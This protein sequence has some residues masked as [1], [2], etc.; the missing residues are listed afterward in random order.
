VAIDRRRLYEGLLNRDERAWRAFLDEFGGLIYSIAIKLRLQES[1]REDFF[2]DVCLLVYDSIGSLR[3][4]D[5]LASWLY[6]I[7]RRRGIESLRRKRSEVPLEDTAAFSREAV[8]C[9]T[10]E[11]DVLDRLARTEAVARLIDALALMQDR[12]R[13][14][15]TALYLDDPRPSYKEIASR[16]R[17]PVGSI[18]PTL[19][20]CMEKAQ[21]IME[22][23]SNKP[24]DPSA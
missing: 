18:G 2:Q 23:L 6:T 13:R 14:L 20:R 9:D 21:K 3:D 7:A 8:D 17:M 19:S 5:H 11:P 12:C 22:E 10:G 4:P 16:E 1:V 15:L 24:S